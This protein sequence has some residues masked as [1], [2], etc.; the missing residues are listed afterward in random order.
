MLIPSYDKLGYHSARFPEALHIVDGHVSVLCC[1]LTVN[2]FR[3]EYDCSNS[4]ANLTAKHSRC[5][6]ASSLSFFPASLTNNELVLAIR[7]VALVVGR[8][9]YV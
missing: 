5:V 6:A 7:H 8:S 2:Q 4:T 1:V 9:H 3:S